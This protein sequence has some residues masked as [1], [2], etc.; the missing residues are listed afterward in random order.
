MKVAKMLS[1]LLVSYRTGTLLFLAAASI[2]ACGCGGAGGS[3]SAPPPPTIASVTVSPQGINVLPGHTQQFAASV[4][5]TGPLSPSVSWSVNGAVGGNQT[6][7]SMDGTG[8]YT[9]PVNSPNPNTVTI[10]ATS[11]SDGSKSGSTKVIVGTTAF[12]I[13]GVSINP[14]SVSLSE[15]STQQFSSAVQGTGTFDSSEIWSAGGVEGGN[16]LS[17]TISSGGL[18]S[19]PDTISSQ[20]SITIQVASAADRSVTASAV[21]TVTQG[22]PFISQIIPSSAGA[23]DQIQIVG[24][25]FAGITT[26]YFPGPGGVQLAVPLGN[27]AGSALQCTVPLSTVSGPVFVQTQQST[28]PV[29][30]SNSA[31]FTRIPHIRIRANRR[32]LS[33]GETVQFQSRILGEDLSPSIRWTADVG[34]I[35][36]AGAYTAPSSLTTDSFAVVTAC[37]QTGNVCEK[38]RLGLHPFRLD[39]TAPVVAEGQSLQLSGILGNGVLSPVWVLNGPG[40]ISPDGL[41]AASSLAPDGGSA[42]ITATSG[43]ISETASI[44]VT[45]AF[46]G[47]VNRVNDYLDLNESFSPFGTSVLSVAASGTRAYAL[48][49]AFTSFFSAPSY[50]WIDIYDLTNPQHP[51]WVDSIESAEPGNLLTCGHF[52]YE[53]ADESTSLGPL[54]VI[55]IFD[56]SGQHP[57]LKARNIDP[58]AV[59]Y[60]SG[61]CMAVTFPGDVAVPAGSS[62]KVDVADLSSGSIIHTP[63]FLPL[64]QTSLSQLVSAT[65][66][67]QRLYLFFDSSAGV[68]QSHLSVFDITK[69]PPKLL[70]DLPVAASDFKP[71][72][73]GH[74]VTSVPR[75]RFGTDSTNVYDVTGSAPVLVGGLPMGAFLDAGPTRAVFADGQI[76]LRVIDVSGSGP[77]LPF[78][79]LFDAELSTQ[80]AAAVSGNLVLSAEGPGGIVIYDTSVPGGPVW[81]EFFDHSS[82]LEALAPRD[83]VATPA[84][85]FVAVGQQSAGG[86]L[87]YNLQTNPASFTGSF[88]TGT[89]IA[90]G[91][92]ISGNT[93]FLATAD[94][95]RILD[96]SSPA[97][98]SQIGV[99]GIGTTALAV[100]GNSLFAG[101]VDN[102]IVVFDISNVSSP[103]Q[104]GSIGI[105][106]LSIQIRISGTRMFVADST[107][108]LLIFDVSSPGTPVLLSSTQPSSNVFGIALDG[109][110]ALLAAWEAGIVIVDCT[111]PAHP[112]V[113]GQA[114]LDTIDPFKTVTA[115]LLNHAAAI[116]LSDGIAFIGVDNFDSQDPPNN[117][118]ATIYGFDYRQPD[119]L[120]LVSLTASGELV[121]NGIITIATNGSSLFAGGDI[122]VFQMD[123]TRPRN[124]IN[125]FF[126][127]DS[128]R[129]PLNLQGTPATVFPVAHD[130]PLFRL[131]NPKSA[132]QAPMAQQMR[133]IHD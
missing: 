72:I 4:Q 29:L 95:T 3:S 5:G 108:G 86:L 115:E 103:V 124:T 113:K 114:K 133:V 63:Y 75:L 10:T 25:G 16:T 51:R 91:L 67:G 123:I 118:N 2:A 71:R 31:A 88:S 100:S 64:E 8:F 40:V 59:S 18:Y 49:S 50:L 83:Q 68:S 45:G 38:F 85:L 107:A 125:L 34:S 36:G 47:M 30:T 76:G 79:N 96:V 105:P 43:G 23:G 1:R 46:P 98:P 110:L 82:G 22:A 119:A 97:S 37:I 104:K 128:L 9:A 52:L 24:R 15:A 84:N 99:I 116:T 14:T 70:G 74:Y 90:Q 80:Q 69:Q 27:A 117:G 109:D 42:V 48:G 126:L 54:G 89:S 102:R 53:L 39:P 56:I 77:A 78:S 26:I 130:R 120:R 94:D 55:S 12:H 121:R 73:S 35:T 11:L 20:S 57:I 66:D 62:A 101:T 81:Q 28:G 17:G 106:D 21:V 112:A 58:S 92:A 65:S 33:A 41:Y 61:G 111:D 127:P 131:T 93:L 32:D 129:P 122:T 13:T 132:T 60:I 7:G 44:G 19:A 87:I 6:L